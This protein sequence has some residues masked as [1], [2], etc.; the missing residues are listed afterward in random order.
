MS[1]VDARQGLLCIAVNLVDDDKESTVDPQQALNSR[2]QC[3]LNSID[4]GVQLGVL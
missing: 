2:A 4:E 1:P 3:L